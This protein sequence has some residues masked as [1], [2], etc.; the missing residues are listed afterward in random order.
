MRADKAGILNKFG[1][2]TQGKQLGIVCGKYG[3]FFV[4]FTGAVCVR[5]FT[6]QHY[7]H[8][9]FLLTRFQSGA[10]QTANSNTIGQIV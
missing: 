9:P 5:S 10:R 7:W 3:V 8:D 1:E 4:D 6:F 2:T